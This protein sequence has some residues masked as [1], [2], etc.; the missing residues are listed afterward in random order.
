MLAGS[1][2][3]SALALCPDPSSCAAPAAPTA[4]AASPAASAPD[5]VCTWVRICF[6]HPASD[7]LEQLKDKYLHI[8]DLACDKRT[9][10]LSLDG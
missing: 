10:I 6:V 9:C 5:P 8:N 2:A 3:R 4:A 7:P 1:P